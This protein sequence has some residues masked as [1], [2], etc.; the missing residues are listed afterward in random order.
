M[1]E[2]ARVCVL[3]PGSMGTAILEGLLRGGAFA[4]AELAVLGRS[5]DRLAQVAG[6]LGIAAWRDADLRD[7]MDAVVLC[8]KPHDLAAVAGQLKPS[9]RESTLVVSTLAGVP[10]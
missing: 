9:L 6:R 5:P 8:C 10:L 4:P 3:G 1:S 2:Q 7:G